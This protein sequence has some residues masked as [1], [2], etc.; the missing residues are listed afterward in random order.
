MQ[1]TAWALMLALRTA[2]RAS[3]VLTLGRDTVDTR[4]KVA[5]LR[6]HKTVE[7]EGVRIVPLTRHALRLLAVLDGTPL[8][9]TAGTVDTFFRRA[10]DNCLIPD[11]HFHDSRAAALTSL[12][13]RVDVMTLARISGHRDI[14]LL[15]RTYYRETAE[16]IA[17]RL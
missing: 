13:R 12:A 15:M 1:A 6:T 11:L 2:M 14:G 16:E 10:R 7:A 17:R 5:T 4:R 9:V 8:D 3:E